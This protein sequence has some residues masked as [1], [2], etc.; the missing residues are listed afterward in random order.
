MRRPREGA[1]ESAYGLAAR[2]E[3]K[4]L[5]EVIYWLDL[6]D[7]ERRNPYSDILGFL[8]DHPNWPGQYKLRG[9]A[10][11]SMPDDLPA[12]DVIAYFETYPP[13]ES[14]GIVRYGLALLR[15]DREAEADAFIRTSWVEEDFASN[16][17]ADFLKYFKPRL[18][19][20][21]HLARLDR[22]LWEGK[23]ISAKRM[24]K[25]VGQDD[26]ALAFARI[27]LRS[28]EPGVDGAIARVPAY[29]RDDPGLIFE[30]LRW[31][32]IKGF[33][34]RAAELLD[35]PPA[36]LVY[37]DLWAQ[38]RLILAR[39]YL[40]RGQPET[41]YRLLAEHRSLSGEF[42]HEVEWL[43]GWIALRKLDRPDVALEHFT[44]FFDN[45]GY[46]IS[47]LEGP[48]GPAGR[49]NRWGNANRSEYWYDIAADHGNTFYGQL[50]ADRISVTPRFAPVPE[51]SEAQIN[52][53]AADELT[54]LVRQLAEVDQ[55]DLVRSFLLQIG[56][57]G[58]SPEEL[59]LT[60]QLA[61]V[62]GRPDLAVAVA[63]DGVRRGTGTGLRGLSPDRPAAG[64]HDRSGA[65]ACHHSSR[66]LV[67]SRPISSRARAA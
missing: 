58:Q 31:R 45:V 48:T 20:E 41:V 43:A 62:L 33:D 6:Q 57:N 16:E 51:P 11:E 13:I 23:T 53:F 42:Q 34:D 25:R 5:A 44:L 55:R 47:R 38:E 15:A 65:G 29:L 28:L 46:P 61:L 49:P 3:D 50:G 7:L 59:H 63:K 32:R 56:R 37:P 19:L 40:E 4:R 21:D 22:L 27:S 1:W 24:L 17:E 36:D 52:A 54:T 9:I 26:A 10:E 30:R 14:A 2:A 60:A 12:A 8:L 18:R 39:R 67:R 35:S 64:K 66:K